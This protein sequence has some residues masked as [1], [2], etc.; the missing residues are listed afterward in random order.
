LK[1][2]DCER[3]LG[4]SSSRW[5]STAATSST[6]SWPVASGCSITPS[7]HGGLGNAPALGQFFLGHQLLVV[8]NVVLTAASDW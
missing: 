1:T 8:R 4:C 6:R 3:T 7:F 5:S 2:P